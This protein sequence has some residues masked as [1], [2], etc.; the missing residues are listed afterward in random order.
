M[1][2]D[3]D[4]RTVGLSAGEFSNFS[5]GPADAGAGSAGLWRAQLGTHWHNAL[6]AQATAEHGSAAEFEIAITGQVFHRGWTF[7]LTGRID[8]LL[9]AAAPPSGHCHV[10]R[11]N[12]T[13]VVLREIKTV[14]RALPVDETELRADYP[15][16]FIQLATYAALRRIATPTETPRA[17][18]VFVE[19]A[20]GLA[21]TIALTSQDDGLFRAQLERVAEFLNLRLRARERLRHLRFSPPFATLRPGQETTFAELTATFEQ[22]PLVLFE[23]PTGF[24]KTGILLEFALG[25]LRAGHVERVLYL[26]SKSTG[27]LQVV[28]TLNAMTA[29]PSSAAVESQ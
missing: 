23:A 21:Q 11:D 28:R 19:T 29:E 16:Y 15:E 20:S 5:L 8:Q 2:F 13:G 12:A 14:T 9:R 27:Q 18:L 3:L 25:Q 22:H 7:T 26:T 1:Q 4:A 6:R 10:L 17:E 24:G